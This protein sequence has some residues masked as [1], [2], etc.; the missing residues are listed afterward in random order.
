MRKLMMLAVLACLLLAGC[1]K[2]LPH[3]KAAYAG[4]WRAHEM[5]LL[6]TVGGDV[7]YTV[8]EDGKRNSINGPLQQ[9][10]GDNFVV[11]MGPL[12]TTFVVTA[13]PHQREGAWHMTV[14]GV[15]LTRD[16]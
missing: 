5:V 6:I 8:K 12:K 2:P 10:E 13:P 7:Q 14:N 4:Y 1:R 15:D 11:G 9:F 16:Q 3:E